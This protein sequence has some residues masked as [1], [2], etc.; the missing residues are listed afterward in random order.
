M[1][2]SLGP[3]RAGTG[4]A[5]HPD[6]AGS[7]KHP[8][9]RGGAPGGVSAQGAWEGDRL[10]PALTRRETCRLGE[11][12]HSSAPCP[13]NGAMGTPGGPH[14]WAPLHRGWHTA[15][16][17]AR[18][19]DALPGAALQTGD[20]EMPPGTQPRNRGDPPTPASDIPGSAVLPVS[21]Q[22]RPLAGFFLPSTRATFQTHVPISI[23]WP[24]TPGAGCL[25]RHALPSVCFTTPAG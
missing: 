20:M 12:A 2:A 19:G 16:P 14:Q 3:S 18:S 21:R 7:A 9:A 4:A 15:A 5:G 8:A 13:G 17:G 22:Q 6:P 10:E 24:C 11:L 1:A 25:A 23:L